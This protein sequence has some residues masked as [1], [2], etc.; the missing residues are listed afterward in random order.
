VESGGV[1]QEIKIPPPDFKVTKPEIKL[2]KPPTVGSYPRG[3]GWLAGLGGALAAGLGALF[4]R[5]KES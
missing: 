5:R 4:N 2:P 1:R 3:A